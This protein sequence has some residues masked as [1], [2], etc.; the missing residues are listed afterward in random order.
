[1]TLVVKINLSAETAAVSCNKPVNL[2]IERLLCLFPA[3]RYRQSGVCQRAHRLR[4]A[5]PLF[6]GK[7]DCRTSHEYHFL[8]TNPDR[9]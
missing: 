5:V 2:N 7:S 9:I 1:M 8:L 4:C 3:S 6:D